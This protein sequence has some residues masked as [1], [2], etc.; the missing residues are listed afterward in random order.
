MPQFSSKNRRGRQP[1]LTRLW[2]FRTRMWTAFQMLVFLLFFSPSV[3]H[4]VFLLS[5]SIFKKSTSMIWTDGSTDHIFLFS[6]KIVNKIEY[7]DVKHAL[8]ICYHMF[9]GF[10]IVFFFI[11]QHKMDKCQW[12]ELEM[13]NRNFYLIII[14]C[15]CYLNSLRK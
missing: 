7:C 9:S 11:R 12:Y 5:G 13:H 10:F 15:Y 8:C 2:P 3:D 4:T 1:I 6:A 14:R